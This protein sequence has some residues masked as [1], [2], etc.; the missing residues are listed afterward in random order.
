MASDRD[1]LEILVTEFLSAHEDGERDALD[2]LCRENPALADELRAQVEL[3][4]RTGL[5]GDGEEDA[6]QPGV[7]EQLGDFRLFEQLG[8]GGMGVV[9][10]AEQVSVGRRVALKIVRPD[11][12][13]FPGARERFRREIETIA[14]LH[15]PGI[16]PLYTVGEEDGLPFYAME[17][18][19]GATLSELIE[20]LR[21]RDVRELTG[22]DLW[23][24]LAPE[25]STSDDAPPLFDGDWEAVCLRIV[26][27][28]AD[29]IAFAHQHGVLHRDI[30]PSNL[31][32]DR[33]GRVRLFDF[34]L[35]SRSSDA[36]MTRTGSLVGS[37]HYMAPELLSEGDATRATDVYAL[38]AT[39][40]ELLTLRTPYEGESFADLQ[41]AIVHG[42]L[43]PPRR[44]NARLSWD[45][46]TV[47][48]KAL[49][50]EPLRRYR[51][52]ADLARDC[53]AAERREPLLARRASR[54]L[55]ARRWLQRNPAAAAA[56]ALVP[57]FLIAGTTALLVQ[58]KGAN[59]E[60]ENLNGR[61]EASNAEL[62]TSLARVQS[63]RERAD[64]NRE[65]ALDAVDS[66]LTRVARADLSGVPRMERVRRRLLE[67]A[68][69]LFDDLAGQAPDSVESFVQY[70]DIRLSQGD[71]LELLG[72]H[73]LAEDSLR[74]GIAAIEEAEARID[75]PA[76]ALRL[77]CLR[78]K[79]RAWY[80]LAEVLEDFDRNGEALEALEIAETAFRQESLKADVRSEIA[81]LLYRRASI[82]LSLG[83][84]EE[85]SAA[86]SKM[87]EAVGDGAEAGEDDDLA[88]ERALLLSSAGNGHFGR[89]QLEEARRFYEAAWEL[90][91]ASEN[92]D[93][94]PYEV[95]GRRMD[96]A[97]NYG[98]LLG[99]LGEFDAARTIL[100]EGIGLASDLADAFPSTPHYRYQV[101]IQ[102]R[103]LAA[104]LAATGELDEAAAPFEASTRAL[105]SLV[106]NHPRQFSYQSAL[107]DTLANRALHQQ[108]RE[109]L[110]SA[111]ELVARSLELHDG[112]VEAVPQDP[113]LRWR[114]GRT[115]LIFAS[116]L[117]EEGEVDAALDEAIAGLE[118]CS[119]D[120][121]AHVEAAALFAKSGMDED[122]LAFLERAQE[123]GWSPGEADVKD[124]AWD[125]I[126][127]NERF[128]QIRD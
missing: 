10:R 15:H 98:T 85:S 73:A 12:L 18:V 20:R 27:R 19:E 111:A 17:F 39:L 33:D 23:S 99:E 1:T 124:G 38:G 64:Q 93:R 120:A 50:P 52:P 103:S 30:K 8:M 55:R 69:A 71:V 115:R 32:L 14:R 5:L 80:Q 28:A 65:R 35:A 90:L 21:E 54:T 77:R 67:D 4:A 112:V 62:E 88:V 116:I 100:T 34:G 108:L 123:L 66:M 79:A 96:L 83:H 59:R 45:A 63:E 46:E 16:V 60:L 91:L 68:R 49:D 114:R 7:P 25:K 24:A 22:R 122:A 94:D 40:Y 101:A 11:Q 75:G 51:S 70:A 109:D 76:D 47:V 92:S 3:L 43:D 126:R 41:F 56:L 119:E 37:L 106:E 86:L 105:E 125:A 74:D 6:A 117:M 48:L 9:H 118:E 87:I 95:R 26:A 13:L 81:K 36:K 72:E 31:M 82:L 58:A 107:A 128:P 2:R 44:H 61:L 84:F 57:L 29:A 42:A 110:A 104:N 127:S 53:E 78:A 89:R 102:S 97:Y 113:H 121:L